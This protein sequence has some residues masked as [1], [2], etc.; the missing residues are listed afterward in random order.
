MIHNCL[1]LHLERLFNEEEKGMKKI[2]MLLASMVGLL[3]LS[4]ASYAADL[5]IGVV[6]YNKVLAENATVKTESSKLQEQFDPQKN[7]IMDFQKKLQQSIKDFNEGKDKLPAVKQEAEKTKISD[8]QK[9]L[10]EMTK[11]YQTDLQEARN[12]STM[13]IFETIKTAITK[14]AKEK[15]IDIVFSNA[16]VQYAKD[17]FDIT[18]AVVAALK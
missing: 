9:Q 10:L 4:T 5:T 12:K 15:N 3:V 17:S 11:T 6:D 1:G 14:I 8:E 16:S 18:N 13:K 2:S 7:K